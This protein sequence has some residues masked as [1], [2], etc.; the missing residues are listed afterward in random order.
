MLED[1]RWMKGFLA[2]AVIV[3]A[4]QRMLVDRLLDEAGLK[5]SKEG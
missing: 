4:R 3:L 5:Y 1:R 2:D